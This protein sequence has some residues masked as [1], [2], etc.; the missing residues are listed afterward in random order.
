[1][2]LKSKIFHQERLLGFEWPADVRL[3]LDEKQFIQIRNRCCELFGEVAPVD[4]D[5]DSIM[6]NDRWG[7]A[8]H[9]EK[10][11]WGRK[12]RLGFA[13]ERA[14]QIQYLNIIVLR[15]VSMLDE[16]G[17]RAPKEWMK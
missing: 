8:V 12:L 4:R 2:K 15:H 7:W 14:L 5:N 6:T 16:L 17:I 3:V 1:M 10:R 9:G 11:T 13:L